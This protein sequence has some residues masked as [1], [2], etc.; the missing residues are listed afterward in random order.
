VGSAPKTDQLQA[1]VDVN[2]QLLGIVNLEAQAEQ[3][4]A[5]LNTLLKRDAATPFTISD[6][7]FVNEKMNLQSLTSKL[8][9]QN[10]SLIRARHELAILLQSKREIHA[11][12]LPVVSLN[13]NYN[14]G[15]SQNSAGFNLYTLNYGPTIGI[16]INIPIFNGNN[17]RNQLRVNEIQQ[18]NNGLQTEWLQQQLNLS[19][20]NAF[21][22]YQTAMNTMET[23]EKNV[24]LAEEN[25]M[26]AMERF[27]KLQSNSIELRQSELSVVDARTRFINAQ[28][29]AKVAEMQMKL[30]VGEVK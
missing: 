27:R 3:T 28:F 17:F 2:T 19:L 29:R 16:G 15:R 23:E 26:I 18:Q 8:P 14:F 6:T 22:E 25:N 1:E 30:L 10:F 7:V 20:Y 21:S 11:Q 24:R 12:R 9:Q 13:G 4:K 5:T